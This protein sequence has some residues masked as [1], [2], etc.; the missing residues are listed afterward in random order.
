MSAL[1][2]KA[3]SNMGSHFTVARNLE[4]RTVPALFDVMGQE[5]A[6]EGD[7]VRTNVLSNLY[8]DFLTNWLYS[9][10][11]QLSYSGNPPPW[12][13]DGWSFVPLD[14][15]QVPYANAVQ[16][17]GS[18]ESNTQNSTNTGLESYINVTVTTPALR[19][20]IECNPYETLNN[21]SNWLTRWDLTNATVWNVSANP[22]NLVW[23]YEL[24]SQGM[25]LIPGNTTTQVVT[26]FFVN[27][28]QVVCCSNETDGIPGT[29]AL[30]YWSYNW[31]GEVVDEALSTTGSSV[32]PTNFTVKWLVGKP[33]QQLYL[34]NN[35]WEGDETGDDVLSHLI[36]T[37]PPRLTAL[38]CLPIIE[39]ANANVTV[40]SG[41][42]VVLE[43]KILSDP[44]DCPDAWSDVY[45]RHNRTSGSLDEEYMQNDTT[46]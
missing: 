24:S 28:S 27:P 14:L 26:S 7:V 20:R 8:T 35:S 18:R 41:T 43:F 29:A 16:H 25:T 23:G 15:S 36:W 12:S 40:D 13:S 10:T 6:D 38:N 11:I 44:V 46:R 42:G 3:P 21:L 4:L 39:S 37:D 33:M 17:S 31:Q 9:A 30:G 5:S 45:S 22:Q 34:T 32:Y 1:W 19:G 2:Q